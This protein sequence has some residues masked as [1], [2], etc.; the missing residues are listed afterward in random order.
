MKFFGTIRLLKF[1][2]A[3]FTQALHNNLEKQF[4]KAAMAFLRAAAP[5]VPVDTGMAR[6]SFLN[7]AK[8]LRTTLTF[9]RTSNSPKRKRLYYHRPGARGERM[10]PQLAQKYSTPPDKTKILKWNGTHI[11]FQYATRVFHFNLHDGFGDFS[12]VHP[13]SR[14]TWKSFENGRKAFIKVI[15]KMKVPK[16]KDFIVRTTVS[17]GQGHGLTKIEEPLKPAT[18]RERVDHE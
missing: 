5:R 7:L 13:T 11:S 14:G 12:G 2:E 6:G 9:S 8:L 15:V 4:R 18:S 1:D 3:K 17:I 16:V 10:N